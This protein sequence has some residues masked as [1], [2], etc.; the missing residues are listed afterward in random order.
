MCFRI[1]AIVDMCRRLVKTALSNIK[2][3]ITYLFIKLAFWVKGII[4]A[5]TWALSI[6]FMSFI[7]WQSVIRGLVMLNLNNSGIITFGVS[8]PF[9]HIFFVQSITQIDL[10]V[11]RAWN[12]HRQTNYKCSTRGSTLYRSQ[13]CTLNVLRVSHLM[14]EF[15]QVAYVFR[16]T[17]NS[18]FPL[19]HKFL[20]LTAQNCKPS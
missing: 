5:T 1:S 16:E 20:N 7:Y 13:N 4:S 14:K 17:S 12:K 2:R 8:P 6:G 9:F 3:M 10:R 19:L 11:R 15:G 18:S